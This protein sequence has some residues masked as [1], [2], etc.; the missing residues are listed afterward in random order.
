MTTPEDSSLRKTPD[1]L[2]SHRWF[3]PD[4]LRSFGHRSR[5]KQMGFAAED[6]ENKPIIGILN[7]WNDLNT[8]HT[9]F[10]DRANEIKR[11]VWQQG[12][13]PV[14]IPVMSL[15]EPFMKPTTM[16]YRSL[17]AMEAE[18]TIRCYPLDG[19]VLMGGCDKTTPALIMGATELDV[20]AIYFPAGPMLKGNYKGITLGSGSDSWKYWDERRAGNLTK[21]EWF[22]VEDSIARSPGHCMTMGTASTMTAVAETLGL[23]LPG[24]SSI[25]AVHSEHAR[26]ATRTGRRIV[27]MVWHDIKPSSILSQPAFENA[28]TADMAIGGS[29]NAIVHILAMAHRAGVDLTLDHFDAISRK[30]PF[31]A[32]IRP[33]G[34]YLMED[35]YDAGGLRAV[36]KNIASLLHLDAPTVNGHTLGQNIESAETFDTDIVRPLNNPLSPEGGTFVLRGNLAPDGCVIKVIAAEKHLLQHTGPAIVFKDYNDLA[37]RIDDPDL[38]VTPESV[39]VLQNAGPLGAPGMPEWGMLPIPKKILE[40]G[41]RDM[42]RISDARMS[43][44]SYGSCILHVSPESWVGGP[45]ALVQTGDTITLDAPNRSLQ[46]NVSDVELA[47]RKTNWSPP[48]PRFTRGYG[49]LFSEQ[50]T[51]AHL[52]CDFKLLHRG[53][54]SGEAEIH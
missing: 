14:E 19:V 21:K 16:F 25:P 36:L 44:T 6:Y 35:F 51:Q 37:A 30:T 7:T 33:S 5:V 22:G 49:K 2:R 41:H 1:Q 53:E 43:G 29:T 52:G 39:I 3:G 17:L 12:G 45:L 4:D 18:E 46:L 54:S 48:N 28:I 31:I 20:P 9:H 23:T 13:F 34:K 15:S 26:M 42:V 10:R 8:C 11:G 24:A 40:Q 38:P 32:N 47:Q 50:T 27:D